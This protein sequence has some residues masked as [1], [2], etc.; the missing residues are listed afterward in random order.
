MPNGE[1]GQP[2]A[3]AGGQPPAAGGEGGTPSTPATPATPAAPAAGEG[4]GGGE[5]H[6][7][8]G[9]PEGS[10]DERDTEILKRFG[11][12]PALAKGYMNA[13]NLVA[14]DKIP[15]PQNEQEFE[16]VYNRLGRPQDAAEYELKFP[17]DMPEDLQQRMAPGQDWFKTAAHSA[18]LNKAQA[19]KLYG[20]YA[21]LIA[22]NNQ[23]TVDRIESE[24]DTARTA[25]KEE[26][27]EAYDGKLTLA[28]RAIS[29]IGGED[30]IKLFEE[31]GMGRNPVVVKAFIKMGEMMA[32][33]TGLDVD[34]QSTDTMQSLDAEIAKIQA[35]PAYMDSKSPEHKILVEKM[36]KLMARRHP[37]PKVGPGTI[38][39]F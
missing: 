26:L 23:A 21:S 37:E 33:E 16:E 15:M 32:E 35:D 11:D 1:G 7:F 39:L 13:F 30:L 10:F 24:M 5:Q 20:E 31:T 12:V 18:G 19:A 6:W 34:G 9:I 8:T 2:A 38:R 4:G 3:P 25:L 36:S 27:G 14:R 29:E 28:N 22:K 17:E